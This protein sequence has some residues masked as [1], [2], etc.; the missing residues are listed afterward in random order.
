MTKKSNKSFACKQK[1]TTLGSAAH[2]S[3]FYEASLENPSAVV[4]S[5]SSF[6]ADVM[7][8]R[9]KASFHA[10]PNII[11]RCCA[12]KD[13]IRGKNTVP[14]HVTEKQAARR[15]VSI[16]Q[17]FYVFSAGTAEFQ[18][19]TM[20]DC[21]RVRELAIRHKGDRPVRKLTE[22]SRHKRGFYC[23]FIF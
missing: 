12:T 2:S 22:F 1:H 14:L 9:L 20:M 16:G 7:P 6:R 23:C 13:I 5:S 18:N 19:E 8:L 3:L 10:S 17:V 15:Y 4:F 21:C 11:T